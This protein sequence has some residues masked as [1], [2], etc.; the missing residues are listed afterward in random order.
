MSISMFYTVLL[1]VYKLLL[2][3]LIVYVSTTYYIEKMMFLMIYL[4]SLRD[5]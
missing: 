2:H 5:E 4:T 3:V 1:V